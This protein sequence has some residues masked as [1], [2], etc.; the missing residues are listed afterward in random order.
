MSRRTGYL[1]S[2]D[3]VP[4]LIF[5]FQFNPDVLSDKKSYKYDP[6]PAFGQWAFDQTSAGSGFFGVL[7]GLLGDVKDIG[8]L[9]INTKPLD[10][11][12]GEPRTV[13]LEFK[14]D[15]STPGPLDGDSHGSILPD[16]AILRSFMAPSLS[17]TDIIKAISTKSIGCFNRPPSCSV[18]YG[19]V[20]MSGVMTDLDLKIVDFF[21][22]GEPRRA[23]ISCT[24]KEQSYS[25]YPVID[26]VTRLVGVFESMGRPGFGLDLLDSQLPTFMADKLFTR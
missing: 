7:A 15:A 9:L 17:I 24:V 16:I 25:I 20:S 14:L 4:P 2:I 3:N 1:S 10:P 26:T 12:E 11:K 22:D 5:R 13:V 6:A 23:E 19:H 18:S 8:A 21:D